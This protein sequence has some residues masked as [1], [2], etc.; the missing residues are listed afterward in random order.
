M[1]L[2]RKVDKLVFLNGKLLLNKLSSI[3][4]LSYDRKYDLQ[5]SINPLTRLRGDNIR[6]FSVAFELV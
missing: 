3:P 4:N 2:I 1:T 5:N 6:I